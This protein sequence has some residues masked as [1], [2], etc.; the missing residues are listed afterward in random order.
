M[1]PLGTAGLRNGARIFAAIALLTVASLPAQTAA[2]DWGAPTAEYSATVHMQES[3]GETLSFRFFH[4]ALRQRLEY[5]AGTDE[6][7]TIVDQHAAAVYVLRPAIKRY[8]TGAQARPEYDFGVSR[9]ETKRE[10]IGEEAV[11]DLPAVKYRVESRTALG[12]EF[13]GLAWL[14]AHRIVLKLDGELKRGRRTRGITMTLSDLRVGPLDPALFQVPAD[15]TP[16]EPR[17]P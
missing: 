11:G 16:V 9:D 13:R 14:G 2:Q 4:T 15:Y 5:R 12:E 17:K 3:G 7:V 10:R 8:R 6:E 1:K